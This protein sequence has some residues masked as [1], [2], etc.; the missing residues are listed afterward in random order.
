MRYTCKPED[1]R[2][3]SGGIAGLKEPVKQMAAITRRSA[4]GQISRILL[5][6][7]WALYGN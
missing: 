3:G 7:F 1:S 6:C 5:D 4:Y 2:I